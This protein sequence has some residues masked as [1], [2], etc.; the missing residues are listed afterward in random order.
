MGW[1]THWM[2]SAFRHSLFK[3]QVPKSNAGRTKPMER[4]SPNE[5]ISP[6][7]NGRGKETDGRVPQGLESPS[8]T[9]P[10]QYLFDQSGSVR[11]Q[12]CFASNFE[13]PE[14][15]DTFQF[16]HPASQI[17]IPALGYEQQLWTRPYALCRLPDGLG[18]YHFTA[19]GMLNPQWTRVIPEIEQCTDMPPFHDMSQIY[20]APFPSTCRPTP[21]STCQTFPSLQ[22]RGPV[23]QECAN[24]LGSTGPTGPRQCNYAGVANSQFHTQVD[25]P[26]LGFLSARQPDSTVD[27]QAHL[28]NLMTEWI[29]NNCDTAEDMMSLFLNVF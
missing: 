11:S 24:P 27:I 14:S 3:K 12:P 18:E 15:M 23:I 25:P 6:G 21:N 22:L 20:E 8:Q 26:T 2:E 10:Q 19:P 9:I 28:S 7:E 17:M 4:R 1:H 16:G 5:S 29:V 13:T